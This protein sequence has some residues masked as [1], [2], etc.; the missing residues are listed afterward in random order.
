LAAR[1]SRRWRRSG[2]VNR[3]PLSRPPGDPG[4]GPVPGASHRQPL[5]AHAAARRSRS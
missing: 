3:E 2:P 4:N 1:G 5:T